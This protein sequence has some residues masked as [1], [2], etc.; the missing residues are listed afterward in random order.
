MEMTIKDWLEIVIIP[1]SLVLIAS[2][3]PMIQN[4]H[5]GRTF[6]NLIFRELQEVG[7]YP[8]EA[9]RDH[10][11]RHL[12]KNFAHR[13]ILSELSDN[14]D[15]VLSLD[16]DLVYNLMQLWD[17]YEARDEQQ[18]LYYLEKLAEYDASGK[19]KQVRAD[20]GVLCVRYR[21]KVS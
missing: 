7:P 16:P 8:K 12:T 20:W 15:F 11:A 6:T 18:W 17:A 5:R 10:W 3:W 9:E 14:R 1:L 2:V 19:L 4:W 13:R 21:G